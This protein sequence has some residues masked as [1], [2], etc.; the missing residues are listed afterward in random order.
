[1]SLNSEATITVSVEDRYDTK[2]I[3]KDKCHSRDADRT[4]RNELSPL[5]RI[6]ERQ[7]GMPRLQ[8]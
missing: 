8:R 7:E 3:D 2:R 5:S 4:M 6:R 1:L